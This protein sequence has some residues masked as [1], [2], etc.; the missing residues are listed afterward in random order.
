[1]N[2]LILS[3]NTGEGH[4]SAGKA[5]KE[6]IESQGDT[7][8]FRDMMLLGGKGT[9]QAVGGAYVN[10]VKHCPFFF[11]LLYRLGRLI[12]S[13]KRK[14]PGIFCLFPFGKTAE[15]VFG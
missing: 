14:S 9:S 7:A 2:V 1:M 4:N 13:S 15:K 10:V 3:C 5:V 8:E 12:S 11:G 6:Y